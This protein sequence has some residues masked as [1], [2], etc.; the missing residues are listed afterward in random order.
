LIYSL[1]CVLFSLI[2]ANRAFTST[3]IQPSIPS[4]VQGK[5]LQVINFVE[6]KMI[7]WPPGFGLRQSSGAFEPFSSGG[8]AA[9]G[10]THSK[11]LP[12]LTGS[13]V[14]SHVSLPN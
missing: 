9:E 13:R 8:K 12:R 1:C 2:I 6:E 7:E 5:I 14:P 3:P 4:S 11:T 10:R